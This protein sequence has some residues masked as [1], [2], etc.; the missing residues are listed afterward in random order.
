MSQAAHMRTARE[1]T[2]VIL[3]GS[4]TRL[5]YTSKKSG[6]MTAASSQPASMTLSQKTLSF[7][8]STL[9]SGSVSRVAGVSEAVLEAQ[10][11]ADDDDAE[12]LHAARAA[13]GG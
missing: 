11:L 2:R 7:V 9:F 4:K 1:R 6:A 8:C 3:S 13:C 10:L 5:E 12:A